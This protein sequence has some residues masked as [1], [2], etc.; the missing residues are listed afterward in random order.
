[1][2]RWAS[3]G[4]FSTSM[5]LTVTRPAVGTERPQIIFR[6]VVLPAPLAP[7]RP[8]TSPAAISRVRRSAAMVGASEPE[9]D[10]YS[11]VRFSRW[12]MR[13]SYR[14]LQRH[15]IVIFWEVKRARWSGN[16][17][18]VRRQP[19]CCD[20]LRLA[21]RWDFAAWGI[22]VWLRNSIGRV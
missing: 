6:V 20:T 3:S 21:K 1:M 19:G 5:S 14:L 2:Y 12:I 9:V 11:L 7:T 17:L 8:K 16:G 13:G 15:A 4:C 22:F 18:G 10:S